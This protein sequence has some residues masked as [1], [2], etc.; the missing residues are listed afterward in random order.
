MVSEQDFHIL[1]KSITSLRIVKF[2]YGTPNNAEISQRVSELGK[3]QWNPRGVAEALSKYTS[4]NLVTLDPTRT[5]NPY[6]FHGDC[7]AGRI[8]VGSLRRFR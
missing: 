7:L 2:H 4:H 1:H 6:Y 3:E 8:F 5:G